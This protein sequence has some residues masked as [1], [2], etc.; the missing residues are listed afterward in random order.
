ML[1]RSFFVE[2]PPGTVTS[3]KNLPTKKGPERKSLTSALDNVTV[4][5]QVFPGWSEAQLSD[6]HRYE[7]L[8]GNVLKYLETL[9]TISGQRIAYVAIGTDHS[10][11]LENQK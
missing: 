6:R 2:E 8:P 5:Y 10:E 3:I 1:F 11:F 4:H 9:S 7:D